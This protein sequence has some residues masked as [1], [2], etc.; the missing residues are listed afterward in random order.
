MSDNHKGGNPQ[1]HTRPVKTLPDIEKKRIR[2]E[3]AEISAAHRIH[4]TLER[5]SGEWRVMLGPYV[6]GRVDVVTRANRRAFLVVSGIEW[7]P[8]VEPSQPAP[9][10][11]SES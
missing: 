5:R 9:A 6:A 1:Q 8:K 2:S 11:T 7:K 3:L 4:Y 10:G